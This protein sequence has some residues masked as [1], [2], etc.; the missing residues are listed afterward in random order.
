[1]S[2]KL[3][4]G[5]GN[6]MFQIAYGLSKGCRT[7]D[8]SSFDNDTLR[9]YEMDQWDLD[10]ELVRDPNAEA[11]YFQDEKLFDKYIAL[12]NFCRPKGT[13]NPACAEMAERIKYTRHSCFIG[14]R[15]ADYLWPERINYHGVMPVEYY[16]EAWRRVMMATSQYLEAFI[17]TDDFHW[18]KENIP[19]TIVDVNGPNEKAWDIWLMSLCK[20]AIIANSSF[21]FWGAWLQNDTG[22]VIAPKKWYAD[23]SVNA[24]CTIVPERWVK[25]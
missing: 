9:H 23:E 16:R 25:I 6:Q 15:R 2:V 20:H 18:A 17:F 4:G 1:M 11:G 22:T 12:G 8:I 14:V 24:Q 10:I 7:F 13:P 21:H 3:Q 19:Y 5:M